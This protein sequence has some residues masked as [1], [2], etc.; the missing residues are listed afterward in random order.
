MLKS[1]LRIVLFL[2]FCCTSKFGI[3][4]NVNIGGVFPTI[5]HSGKLTKKL[6]YSLYYFGAFPI[7]N[8]KTP[9]L[10]NDGYFHLFYAEQAVSYQ[11]KPK[12]I[13]TGSY[14]YQRENVV[15]NNYVNENRFYIQAKYKH[16]FKKL[17]LSHR[18]RFDAR[19]IH[20]R[21]TNFTP[22]THRIRY[23]LG[24]DIPINEKTYITAY[25]EVFF[26][27]FKSSGP[28]YGENW[29]Y[30]AF[31]KKLSEKNK[32]EAGLLYVT[33]NLGNSNWFNQYYIQFTW[34]NSLNFSKKEK[35]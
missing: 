28:I 14:V 6:N 32:I 16:S 27:S 30:V 13:L 3:T 10:S 29:G 33:W 12:I 7:V 22:F 15:Y 1:K 31:G 24:F 5:D 4:Q 20:N 25:E 23:Q 21:V 19:F 17:N 26:N 18:V 8:F 34:I 35:E 2:I 11:I 9:N